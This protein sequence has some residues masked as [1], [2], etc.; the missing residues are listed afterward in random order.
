MAAPAILAKGSH[1]GMLI[2]NG[3]NRVLA[4]L[5]VAVANVET[6]LVKVEVVGVVGTALSI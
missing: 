6:V 4:I 2:L 1:E 3:A 5:A